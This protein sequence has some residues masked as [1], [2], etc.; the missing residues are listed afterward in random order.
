[1]K[2]L[3]YGG[4]FSPPTIGHITMAKKL[5]TML[6]DLGY[7]EI[8]VMPCYASFTGKILVDSE[9]R[10]NMCKLAFKNIKSTKISDFEIR[11]KLNMETIDVVKKLIETYPDI[12]FGFVFG[13]DCISSFYEW[14]GH[15][16]L[17][18]LCNFVI[19]NRKG[20]IDSKSWYHDPPHKFIDIDIPEVSS[21][22]F[23]KFK[24]L[25][26]DTKIKQI[27]ENDIYCY[28]ID[29]QLYL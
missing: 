13:L 11:N 16:E 21:T 22:E 10:L 24:K 3:L 29:N 8:W 25:N 12:K 18:R 23:R 19:V 4:S 27:I 6:D 20:Y 1:M 28:I 17:T 15:D 2:V 14:T 26:D 9:H 5:S 7:D